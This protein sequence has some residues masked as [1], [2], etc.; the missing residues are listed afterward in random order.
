VSEKN[1]Y[2]VQVQLDQ[3]DIKN[4]NTSQPAQISPEVSD[5]EE[6]F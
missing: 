1:S 2:I 5:S 6:L 3:A 4:I